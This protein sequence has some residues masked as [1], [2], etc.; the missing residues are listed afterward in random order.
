MQLQQRHT[1]SVPSPSATCAIGCDGQGGHAVA[2][3]VVVYNRPVASIADRGCHQPFL[4]LEVDVGRSMISHVGVGDD[5]FTQ[6][7]KAEGCRGNRKRTKVKSGI[8]KSVN[9]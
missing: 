3:V 8:P 4:I 5:V 1:L 7:E 9:I 6:R 2:N